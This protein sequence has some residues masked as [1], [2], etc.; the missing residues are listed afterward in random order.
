MLKRLSM[1]ALFCAG[2]YLLDACCGD[3]KPFFDY[4]KLTVYS[5]IVPFQNT[6]DSVLALRVE[7]AEVEYLASAYKL[8]IGTP[9]YGTSCPDPG[10]EGTKYK[11]TAVDIYAD[12]NFNDTLPA[13]TSLS[14]IFFN[15]RSS[16]T[17]KPIA[18]GVSELEF[19]L[20]QWDFLIYTPLEPTQPNQTF[21]LTVKITKSDGSVAEGKVTGV[22]FK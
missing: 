13:G 20:P 1:L 22:K 2:M 12:K 14:S 16:N 18:Q 10:E 17:S 15:G 6:A 9:A 7:P 3:N 19:L 11:M 4:Q 21:T 5:A 8:T